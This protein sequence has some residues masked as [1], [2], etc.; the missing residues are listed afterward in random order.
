MRADHPANKGTNNPQHESTARNRTIRH[1][2]LSGGKIH[3]TKPYSQD[4]SIQK[5]LTPK[6]CISDFI[7]G[8]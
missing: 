1:R 8:L 7:V 3:P 6:Y 5:H 2:G 4:A